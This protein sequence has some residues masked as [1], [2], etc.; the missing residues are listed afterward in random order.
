MAIQIFST[1]SG[2]LLH[3]DDATSEFIINPDG[4]NSSLTALGYNNTRK[5]IA[6]ISA[7]FDGQRVLSGRS[8]FTGLP[9]EFPLVFLKSG[10]VITQPT[11]FKVYLNR[12]PMIA[13]LDEL[14]LSKENMTD[15]G[16]GTHY[17]DVPYA[18]DSDSI[19]EQ[20]NLTERW[21]FP[22][23]GPYD[24][25]YPQSIS[26]TDSDTGLSS[27]ENY[28]ITYAETLTITYISD[29]IPTSSAVGFGTLR[30][31]LNV[32]GNPM[33]METVPYAKGWGAHAGGHIEHDISAGYASFQMI[34][35]WDDEA[36]ARSSACDIDVLLDGVSAYSFRLGTTGS[37]ENVNISVSGKST[38][39][40][41]F[42]PV[43]INGGQHLDFALARLIG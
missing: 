20:I 42:T 18:I 6:Q 26:F 25:T 24:V 27:I 5:T 31:D 29:L 35:G 4:L 15:N 13:Y 12:D 7:D 30:K 28:N 22:S 8:D 2:A 37:P 23:L 38:L 21:Y 16:D 39:R 32:N 3:Y 19:Y 10:A 43:A 9:E 14:V 36:P 41:N 1:G 34:Y 11:E 40:I 17:I 33:A